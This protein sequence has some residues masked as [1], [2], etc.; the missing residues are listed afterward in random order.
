VAVSCMLLGLAAATA[1]A[2][3]PLLLLLPSLPPPAAARL[4]TPPP[5][6]RPPPSLPPLP[7]PLSQPVSLLLSSLP[8]QWTI[9]AK[10]THKDALRSF[11]KGSGGSVF[12]A[13][14]ADAHVS[15]LPGG[16]P[17]VIILLLAAGPHELHAVHLMR[18]SHE[19]A[20][21]CIS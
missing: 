5:L 3:A 20:A 21:G 8:L 13:E 6:P 12:S 10:V 17:L 14:L 19:D 9:K 16:T 11:N 4:W 2:A 1:V 18:Q 15:Q 7:P